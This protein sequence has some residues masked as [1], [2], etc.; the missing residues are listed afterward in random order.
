[1]LPRFSV[2][3]IYLGLAVLLMVAGVVAL[4]ADRG[5]RSAKA[6]G[7]AA[8]VALIVSVV[9]R[10]FDASMSGR[11]YPSAYGHVRVVEEA[12]TDGG[13]ELMPVDRVRALMIDR[14]I[15]AA[16]APDAPSRSIKQYV[17]GFRAADAVVRA[18]SRVLA[19]GGGGF[20]AP[21]EVLERHPDARV[22]A[23]E[24]DPAVVDAAR[25]AFALAED[26]RMRI[27]VEDARPALQRLE[28]GYDLLLADVYASSQLGVPWYL[29]TRETFRAYAR[30]LAPTGVL[31]A[32]V[33][34]PPR[35]SGPATTRF[36]ADFFA[37]LGTAF[38]WV[39]PVSLATYGPVL[40]ANTLVFA[41]NGPEPDHASV[42]AAVQ[43]ALGSPIAF[44]LEAPMGGIAW[45]DDRGAAD[46][47][48]LVAFLEARERLAAL[49]AARR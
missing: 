37:T 29:M 26:P 34:L 36:S 43:S 33:W 49:R 20:H 11:T 1:M 2:R 32:N 12:V 21:R 10:P 7:A 35:P 48:F 5:S 41:G 23:I 30:L 27:L 47:S 38:R 46:Y 9:L 25:D 17:V 3:S 13:R 39:V 4:L 42:V 40:P 16:A 44:E 19:L 18:P 22:D 14:A 31:L 15:H 28:A 45:T 6:L 24:I 8:C